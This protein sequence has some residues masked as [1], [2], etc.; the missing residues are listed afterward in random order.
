MK[1]F[2]FLFFSA[3]FVLLTA[4]PVAESQ[5]NITPEDIRREARAACIELGNCLRRARSYRSSELAACRTPNWTSRVCEGVGWA[6]MLFNVKGAGAGCQ[7]SLGIWTWSCRSDV[8]EKYRG[9]KRGC[10]I[11]YHQL[12]SGYNWSPSLCGHHGAC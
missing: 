9:K 7:S 6:G 5:R 8:E 4:P 3:V 11:N 2:T 1:T 12:R 10:C